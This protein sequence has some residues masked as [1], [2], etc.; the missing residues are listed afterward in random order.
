M[1]WGA[2]YWVNLE[3]TTPPEFGKVRPCLVLSNTE[4]NSILSTVVV[5]PLSTRAPEI[6]PLRIRIAVKIKRTTAS[7]VV[8][9]G[10]RQVAKARM[11]DRLGV[12]PPAVMERIVH[13]VHLYLRD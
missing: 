1:N 8:V 12:L 5:L 2:I 10:I 11:L 6:W 3:P 4:Q 9:P 7:Y 13:G